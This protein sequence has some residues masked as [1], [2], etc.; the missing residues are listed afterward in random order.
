MKQSLLVLVTLIGVLLLSG[1]SLGALDAANTNISTPLNNS[2]INGTKDITVLLP[3]LVNITIQYSNDSGANYVLLNSTENATSSFT[4]PWNTTNGTFTDGLNYSLRINVTNSSDDVDSVILFAGNLTVDNAGP[5][6][7]LVSPTP[8][9]KYT[10]GMVIFIEYNV[11]DAVS[12]VA[13]GTDC[14]LFSGADLFT[15]NVLYNA[16]T[17]RCIGNLTLPIEGTT[18]SSGVHT[19]TLSVT[20][21]AGN[22]NGT[23]GVPFIYDNSTPEISVFSANRTYALSTASIRFTLNI[24]DDTNVTAANLSNTNGSYHQELSFVRNSSSVYTYDL[25]ATLASFGCTAEGA[26]SLNVTARDHFNLTNNTERLTLTI[27]ETNP[28]VRSSTTNVSVLQQT[29]TIRVT[30]N[31]TDAGPLANI[32]LTNGTVYLNMT[33]ATGNLYQLNTTPTALGCGASGACTFNISAIDAA[34][35]I[36][37]SVTITLTIDGTKPSVSDFTAN[38]S[39]LRQSASIMLTVNVTDANAL[40]NVSIT[41]GSVYVNMTPATGNLFQVNTTPAALGC[42]ANANCTINITAIDI[43]NNINNSV[44]LTLAI[45]STN[46]AVNSITVN[47]SYL[48]SDTPIRL[49]ANVTDSVGVLN[50]SAR[51]VDTAGLHRTMTLAG[52]NLYELNTTPDFL[53]CPDD[54]VC[55]INITTY[56]LAGNIN[57]TESINFT[58][59]STSPTVSNASSNSS[60]ATLSATV[61][62]RVNVTD[63]NVTNVTAWVTA[64]VVMTQAEGNMFEANTTYATL[65]CSS[66]SVCTIFFNATDGA[67]NT[68]D[69]T[70]LNVTTDTLRPSVSQFTANSTVLQQSSNV[71]LTVN[72]TD[73]S[74]LLNVSVL[75]RTLAFNMT[76]A[77]GNLYQINITPIA[78]G[79]AENGNCTINISASDV[80]GN[81]NN[82]VMLTLEVDTTAPEF[83]FVTINTTYPY[84]RATENMSITA[85]I[86]DLH[87]ITSAILSAGTTVFNLTYIGYN[88]YQLNIT[89]A[90]LECPSNGICTFG[91]NF[92]DAAGNTNTYIFN[93]PMDSTRPNVTNYTSNTTYLR[94]N[95]FIQLSAFVNDSAPSGLVNLT[96]YSTKS[97][98]DGSLLLMNLTT[99]VGGYGI[100]RLNTTPST[101][102]CISNGLCTVNITAFDSAGNINNTVQLSFIVDTT[103]P[104]LTLNSPANRTNSS[105]SNVTFNFTSV[106]MLSTPNSTL[107]LNGTANQSVVAN[108]TSIVWINLSD[109]DYHWWVRTVDNASN[110][111]TS[112][113]RTFT[114]DATA[115]LIAGIITNASGNATTNTS[116]IYVNATLTE[117]HTL[118][119]VSIGNTTSISMNLSGTR[120]QYNGTLHALGCPGDGSCR[121]VITA[122]D[123]FGNTRTSA[124]TMTLASSAPQLSLS[125]PANS[126]NLTST[127]VNFSWITNSTTDANLSCTLYV[128]GV[129]NATVTGN[130]TFASVQV[131]PQGAGNWTV[132][133]ADDASNTATATV[134]NFLLDSIAPVVR[135]YSPNSTQN[136]SILLLNISVFEA[137]PNTTFVSYNLTN[138]SLVANGSIDV[139][140]FTNGTN[141]TYESAAFFANIS[142]GAYN[143]TVVAY[144]QHGN[145]QTARANFTIIDAQA[146][147]VSSIASTVTSTSATLSGTSLEHTIYT[148]FYGDSLENN[149]SAGNGT[150]LSMTLSSLS[151]STSYTYVIQSC[152]SSGNCINSSNNTFTTSA[153]ATTSSGGRSGGG[154]GG[155]GGGG[156]FIGIGSTPQTKIL[157]R[158]GKLTLRLRDGSTHTLSIKSIENGVVTLLIQSDPIEVTMKSGETRTVDVDKDG[159]ADMQIKILS[160]TS[161]SITVELMRAP[162]TATAAPAPKNT[163]ATT[164]PNSSKNTTAAPVLEAVQEPQREPPPQEIPPVQPPAEVSP[165]PEVEEKTSYAWVWWILLVLTLAGLAGWLVMRHERSPSVEERIA[166]EQQLMQ[167][168]REHTAQPQRTAEPAAPTPQTPHAETQA[169]S[170]VHPALHSQHRR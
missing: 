50:V 163:T 109:G 110:S 79:C 152:D 78:L 64:G 144:D 120:Y 162:A 102:G 6:F 86:S 61:R 129:A 4:F 122:T 77:S 131:L 35:N 128:N 67:G 154:G 15:G 153:A 165:Q 151:A 27:D 105:A 54:G 126:A 71:T 119:N 51:N 81:V 62:I 66:N 29:Q 148:I 118:T 100:Y 38:T 112:E 114:V 146:P 60:I 74:T 1:L 40:A 168:I 93:M 161:S 82:S 145:A 111:N 134:R 49:E 80:A 68:N 130:G 43:A 132:Q 160:M 125:S 149:V 137:R 150:S 76:A 16:S 116:T 23:D 169:H 46:P 133:C 17:G 115:P 39:L 14:N 158:L 69:L 83:S 65:G 159:A 25:N 5:T 52:G 34:G 136:D 73:S 139:S 84:I 37:N 143:L 11:T 7:T 94:D 13:N 31:V 85:G 97:D 20:D 88:T 72:V 166:R 141:Y 101:L 63:S 135:V 157:A 48:R 18:W 124:F 28:A 3:G 156:S 121:L 30:V 24:T 53:A 147:E 89:P 70:G 42:N 75:N 41:N 155:G 140:M 167:Q 10:D 138:G 59:D 21:R 33:P 19:F 107:Y 164:A 58:V 55:R 103:N 104:L 92:S 95:D 106:D 12:G 127:S 91:A 96:I 56:D 26:C 90:A 8:Y 36:N 9:S 99:A 123:N 44:S 113:N 108:G 45:D 57:F 22:T 117:A 87:N 32:S 47:N 142:N 170:P 2:Y 98:G